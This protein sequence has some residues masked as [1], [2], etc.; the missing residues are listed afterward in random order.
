VAMVLTMACIAGTRVMSRT[1][2]RSILILSKAKRGEIAEARI[3]GAEIV[4]HDFDPEQPQ[5]VELAERLF[6]IVD[7]QTLGDLKLKSLGRKPRF[8]Q[9]M[10]DGQ[11]HIGAAKSRRRKID[12]DSQ[13][14]VPG[15]GVVAGG[16]APILRA[17]R[18]SRFPPPPR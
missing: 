2:S 5:A 10:G 1:N 6:S 15:D 9:H 17:A 16:G 4:H 18:S 11:G 7:E 12:R 13:R 8:A 14:L 3:T